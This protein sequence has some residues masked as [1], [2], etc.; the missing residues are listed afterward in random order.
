ML[1]RLH[2]RRL[3]VTVRQQGKSSAPE[4][5][6]RPKWAAPTA[7]T[8]R[9]GDGKW[10]QDVSV[11]AFSANVVDS[12]PSKPYD[13]SE[14]SVEDQYS[15]KTPIEHVLLR[16]S[17][18]IGSNERAPP[19]I[20][21]VLDPPPRPPTRELLVRPAVDQASVVPPKDPIRM[22]KKEYGLVPALI[23]VRADSWR[24]KPS[25]LNIAILLQSLSP[26][27]LARYVSPLYRSSMRFSLMQL[28]TGIDTQSHVLGLT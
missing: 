24:R 21:W 10:L 16:P 6:F 4:P 7:L 2:F 12:E 23:K 9:C 25:L 27:R 20:C 28:I 1:S 19:T 26:C 18:Y 3:P 11:R 22:V 14:M 13:S 5:R 15:R 8:G 17:M